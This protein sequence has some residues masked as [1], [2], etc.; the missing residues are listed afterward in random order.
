[1]T[2]QPLADQ[3]AGTLHDL[4]ELARRD[5]D[6]GW[7]PACQLAVARDGK[8]LTF[9]TLGEAGPETRFC[10]FSATKPLVASAVWHLLAEGG[11]ELADPAAEWVPE[12][13]AGGMGAV[14]IEQLLL[15][16]CGF[17]NAPMGPIEGGDPAARRRR[18]GTWRLEW[19]PGSRFEYHATSA[20]WV[21]ADLIERV[22]GTDFRDFVEERVCRPL[23]LP[24]LLGVFADPSMEI[25]PLTWVGDAAGTTGSGDLSF[26]WDAPDILSAGAPG[27]GGVAT[28]AEVAL[29]YQALLHNPGGLWDAAVLEDATSQVRCTF[30][31]PLLGVAVNRT[32]GLVVAG[33]DGLQVMR[34]GAFAER[35]SAGSFG[36]AGAHVQVAWA[37]PETGVS[38]AYLTNGLDANTLKEGARGLRL[39]N[40]AASIGR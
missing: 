3:D 23:G 4:V 35:N 25:A 26:E 19:E 9:A 28:A 39:S 37:D 34:Y 14:T 29:F 12:L 2:G 17:P 7:L 10:I 24:R 36:H 22:S 31:D 1:M 13:A 33:D 6:K 16:T 27:A 40:L 8:L 30:P 21:L 5:V 20:H 11:L 18:F 32:I 38:F 15:H